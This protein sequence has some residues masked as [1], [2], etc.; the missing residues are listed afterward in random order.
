[1][2]SAGTDAPMGA[3]LRPF[4]ATFRLWA[5]AA[6][7]VKVRGNFTN[8][9]DYPLESQPG[10]YWFASVDGVKEGDEYLY[11][12]DGPAG[13]GFKRDPFARALTRIPAFPDCN[14]VVT[15]PASFPWHDQGFRP[16]P[17][18]DLVIYQFHVGAFWSV[19]NQGRDRRADRPGRFLDLLERVDYF[20][21][22][23]VNAVQLLPIQEFATKRSLGYNGLD[24]FSPEMDYSVAPTDPE[25]ERYLDQAN[26][27]LARFG[28]APLG[29]TAID[30]Q[31]KQLMAVIDILH[32]HGISVILDLVYNHA[33]GGFDAKSLFFLDR[34]WPGDNNRSL[35]FTD[36]GWAGGLI[37]AYW[38]QEVRQFLIDNAGLFLEEYHVDGFRFDEVTVIDRYGGWHFLQDLTETLRFKRPQAPLI[39]EY[40]ADQSAVLRARAQDGAGFDA[41]VSSNLREAIRAVLEQARGGSGAR[42]DLDALAQAL[43][44]AGD[45]GWRQVQ[46]LE[47]HDI[48]RMDNDNDREARMPRHADPSDPR[49]WFARSR[50]RVATGLLL[51]SP[52]IPMIFMGE[53]ILEDEYW[54]D[55]PDYFRNALVNWQALTT[56]RS[57]QD[58]FR[59]IRE[60]LGLRRQLPALRDGRLNVFH[61]HNDNRVIA[62]HRWCEGEGADVVV[63]AN[64][65]EAP[66]HG[67]RLGFPGAGHWRE[68]FNSDTYEHW[69]N[70]DIHGNGGGLDAVGPALH[71]FPA[72]AEI[73]VP[74]NGVVLFSR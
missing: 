63:V 62:Y 45:T 37:F 72:S 13:V 55:S 53:E 70:P 35:Y 28:H 3:N 25:F 66:W 42:L 10:G 23:G 4:G 16:P 44:A 73:V 57:R 56:D 30:C 1:M 39:A 61:V 14:C 71:G 54:S 20:V 31:T 46:H 65:C 27:L 21:E 52:G 74:A 67:Y 50:S 17:F 43:R 9:N 68:R 19:D 6:R 22:L 12:V 18:S 59:F 49:S 5:P 64:L 8:W 60:L 33:G 34:D 36:Q 24:L 11:V 15:E 48:V 47:N 26:G 32:L 41:V 2:A 58:F 38:K 69:V 51:T 29:P 40:W 7:S